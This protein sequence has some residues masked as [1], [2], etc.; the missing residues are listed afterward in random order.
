MSLFSG[1]LQKYGQ[2]D[3]LVSNAAANL[4]IDPIVSMSEKALDKL[5]E[6]NV[7]ASI[8]IV[9]AA[10]P[11]LS[12]GSSVIFVTSVAAFNPGTGFLNMYAV[13]K[14]ALLGLTKALAAEL[15]PKTRVN[16]IAPGFV[17]TR[18]S[19]FLAESA[20]ILAEIESKILLKRL[21][22]TDDMAAAA[23]FLASDDASYITGETLVIAGG[24]Q[25]RL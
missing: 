4:S 23:A 5:W 22:T 6:I 19:A 13:M 1:S 8:Q 21:G 12:D 9:Q 20:E 10:A 17:P 25:S 14:T 11:F 2:I 3:I 18:F 16:G 24:A 15:A 7:K